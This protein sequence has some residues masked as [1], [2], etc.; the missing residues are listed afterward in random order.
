MA[1]NDSVA[2]MLTLGRRRACR[3]A[4]LACSALGCGGD[5][6][7][8]TTDDVTDRKA[9]EIGI[10]TVKSLR[11]VVGYRTLVGHLVRVTGR[12]HDTVRE[13]PLGQSPRTQ[14]AWLLES[15]GVMVF[16]TGTTPTTCAGRTV[17]VVTVTAFVAEDTLPAIGDLPAVARR[18]LVR[19]RVD[20]EP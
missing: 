3:W 16:V 10:D 19:L 18:F 4:L 9:P 5:R 17:A 8:G 14:P 2:V 7:A 20:G 11:D 1:R 13:R 15:D 12:C 6:S